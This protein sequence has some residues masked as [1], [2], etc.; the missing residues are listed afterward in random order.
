MARIAGE[1]WRRATVFVVE[2]GEIDLSLNCPIGPVR[3]MFFPSQIA[4]NCLDS[5]GC[6]VNLPR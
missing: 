2:A 4:K 5:T 1:F 3:N 6:S